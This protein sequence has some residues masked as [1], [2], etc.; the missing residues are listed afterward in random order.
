MEPAARTG[1]AEKKMMQGA[2]AR[3][4]ALICAF[5]LC[6]VVADAK[7]KKKGD[8]EEITQTLEVIPDP[9][10]VITVETRRLAFHVTP[11]STKGLLSQQTRDAV[12]AL[13]RQTRGAQV[14]KIR[15]FVAGSADL[16]RVPSIVAELFTE[17]RQPLPVVS[18]IQVGALP[19]VGA[20]VVLEAVTMEKKEVNPLGLA[21][22]SGQGQTDADPLANVMPLAETAYANLL[23]AVTAVGSEPAD[24]LRVTCFH[25]N[26]DSAR[27]VPALSFRYFPKAV[28]H[29]VQTQRAPNRAVAECE[30]VARL[31][32]PAQPPFEL[33]NPDTLRKSPAYSQIAAISSPKVVFTGTQMEFGFRD[34]DA[35]LAFQRMDRLLAG[36]GSSL[37]HVAFSS[38]YPLSPSLAEQVRRIR[39]DFF[40]PA[41]PPASTLLVFE[42]LPAMEAGFALEVVAVPR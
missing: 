1:Y 24:V 13:M 32:K 14:V 2:P 37:K 31:R 4:L 27:E 25:S 22:I 39:F 35:K 42:G 23:K 9:P 7:K 12:K 34:E 10:P 28:F 41:R 16:R 36:A 6:A 19:L 8:E 17:K 33:V 26:L 3:L 40:D 29:Q 11:L 38:V 15:A 18:V 20:Q 5:T 21:W 30:A